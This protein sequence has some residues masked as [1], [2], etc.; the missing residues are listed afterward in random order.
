MPTS[1]VLLDPGFSTPSV[2]FQMQYPNGTGKEKSLPVAHYSALH[3]RK[4][5]GSVSLPLISFWRWP[6]EGKYWTCPHF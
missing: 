6:R 5:N 3:R 2:P 4:Q 1:A